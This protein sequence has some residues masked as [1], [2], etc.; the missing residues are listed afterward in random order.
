MNKIV[1]AFLYK[2]TKMPFYIG[3]GSVDRARDRSENS[4]NWRWQKVM[5]ALNWKNYDFVI[6]DRSLT[7]KQAGDI[8]IDLIAKF[9]RPHQ[10]GWGTLT[11]ISDGGYYKY[12]D[13]MDIL[14]FD[15]KTGNLIKSFKGF[16]DA[17]KYC[18]KM[19]PNFKSSAFNL[20]GK[21]CQVCQ[22][23]N[24]SLGGFQWFYKK[25]IGNLNCVGPVERKKESGGANS[26]KKT[27]IGIKKFKSVGILWCC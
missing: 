21:I 9:G 24:P 25:D 10:Q 22:N 23:S 20:Q 2:D 3:I 8:E 6:V 16:E 27:I 17:G 4:R 14:A 12:K 1:Y 7:E 13:K 5:K 11:N 26:S 19:N 15:N 18:K